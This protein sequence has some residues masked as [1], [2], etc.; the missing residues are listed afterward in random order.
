MQTTN[1]PSAF[2]YDVHVYAGILPKRPAPWGRD[3]AAVCAWLFEAHGALLARAQEVLDTATTFGAVEY[4]RALLDAAN[5][6]TALE[7]GK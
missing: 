5:R 2:V 4:A 3:H 1:L 7:A 6:I